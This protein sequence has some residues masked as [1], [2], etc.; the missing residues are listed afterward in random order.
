MPIFSKNAVNLIETN[1]WLSLGIGLL[2]FLITPLLILL[3]SLTLIG[4]PLALILLF[5]YLAH[6]YF[7]KIFV[8]IFLGQK[9]LGFFTKNTSD[10]L[11]LFVGLVVYGVLISVPF[12]GW[13]ISLVALFIGVGSM[14]IQRKKDYLAMRSKKII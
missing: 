6:L 3:L 8:A 11:A 14:V 7:G 2:T 1:P 4:I 9:T 5:V 12:L 10:I 13:L